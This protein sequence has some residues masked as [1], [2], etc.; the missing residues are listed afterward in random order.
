MKKL[1]TLAAA[2]VLSWSATA[3]NAS[4]Y[5]AEVVLNYNDALLEFIP[6]TPG[7]TP[8]V[9]ARA[10]GY[11]G[12]TFYESVQPGMPEYGSL[13]G[14][15]NELNS[16]PDPV[17]GQDYH[18]PT[19]ANNAMA[20]IIDSLFSNLSPAHQA[21]LEQIRDDY[22]NQFSGEVSTAIY[23]ASVDF[24]VD[25][26]NAI[27]DYSATDG[28]HEG[29]FSNFPNDFTPAEGPGLWEPLD[30]QSALQ[31]YWGQLRTF[32][33]QNNEESNLPPAPPAFSTDEESE[34]YSYAFQVYDAVNN[35]TEDQANIAQWWA[36]GANTITPPG[37]SVSLMTQ[38]CEETS[39]T[40][41]EAA[42][43]YAMLGMSLSDA[44]VACWN[45]K[46]I[47]NLVRP[48]TY[49][50]DHIDENWGTTVATPPFPEYVSGHSSQSGAMG[51]ILTYRFGPNYSFSDD[52]WAGTFGEER[53]FTN[54]W[55]AAEEAA[56]S[57]MYGGIHYQFG[58][59]EGLFL[60]ERV[61]EN[62]ISLFSTVGVKEFQDPAE[63]FSMYPNPT[64][65]QLFLSTSDFGKNTIRIFSATGRLVKEVENVK[66]INTSELSQGMYIL[67]YSAEG[68]QAPV[69]KQ[70]VKM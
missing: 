4:D 16:V 7:F 13:E 33:A 53:Y 27:Y 49:I 2:A 51:E 20:S 69:K 56:I 67:E 48:I 32:V 63:N 43:C 65:D 57:R 47:H 1:F 62:I 17:S 25:V 70:F 18:W 21:Q 38:V 29:Q 23:N 46:Y 50:Q 68:M 52:T 36:D 54:F 3:Q 55:H 31:P 28:G 35:C 8:P 41:E 42:V 10:F 66:Q 15:A 19:V 22:N 34:F 6:V 11:I 12:L 58:N 45:S 61:G 26:A 39:A 44:F 24:G 5:S 60:G 64:S 14:M 59:D 30:G 37:H 40:L 9:T